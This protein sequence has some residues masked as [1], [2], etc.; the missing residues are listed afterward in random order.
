MVFLNFLK[1][2]WYFR[3]HNFWWDLWDFSKFQNFGGMKI[4]RFS[5]K[6][7]I[8]WYIFMKFLNYSCIEIIWVKAAPNKSMYNSNFFI[9]TSNFSHAH[10]KHCQ[11]H[12]YNTTYWKCSCMLQL[13]SWDTILMQ[14]TRQNEEWTGA[15]VVIGWILNGS[16]TIRGYSI[17]YQTHFKNSIPCLRSCLGGLAKVKEFKD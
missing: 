17:R 3:A 8:F 5:S 14:R 4:P 13:V 6:R 9:C 12:A 7:G 2:G 16:S 1:I 11:S 15:V 10:G